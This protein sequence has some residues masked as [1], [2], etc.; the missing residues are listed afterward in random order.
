M[1]N[2]QWYLTPTL[3]NGSVRLNKIPV[4]R[5]SYQIAFPKH[6]LMPH[7]TKNV[8]LDSR[9]HTHRPADAYDTGMSMNLDRFLYLPPDAGHHVSSLGICAQNDTALKLQGGDDSSGFRQFSY[10][11]VNKLCVAYVG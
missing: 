9:T 7:V 11:A 3:S 5:I 2:A 8:L 6:I 4:Y 1:N 10:L